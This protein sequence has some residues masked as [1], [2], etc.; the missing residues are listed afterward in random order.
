MEFTEFYR[1]IRSNIQRVFIINAGQKNGHDLRTA[2]GLRASIVKQLI[3]DID[4]RAVLIALALIATA[5]S[6][7]SARGVLL[8]EKPTQKSK[9]LQQT[10]VRVEPGTDMGPV[11]ELILTC[12]DHSTAIVSFSKT[13]R[14]FCGPTGCEASLRSAAQQVCTP[15]PM[16]Q[17]LDLR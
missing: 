3:G 8:D 6:S 9:P 13:D 11:L 2:L 14:M 5:A 7:A 17:T 16:V 1:V 10:M 4:M 12:A 15:R